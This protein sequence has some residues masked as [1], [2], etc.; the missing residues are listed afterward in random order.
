V[1]LDMF[2]E[3]L[4]ALG[5]ASVSIKLATTANA[6]TRGKTTILPFKVMAEYA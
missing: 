5:M 2:Q 3:L 4:G 6:H 1:E